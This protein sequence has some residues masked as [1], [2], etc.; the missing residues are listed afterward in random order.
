MDSRAFFYA[1]KKGECNVHELVIASAERLITIHGRNEP[2][3]AQPRR[4]R[5]IDELQ[6]LLKREY[7]ASENDPELRERFLD[8]IDKMLELGL[9]GVDEI[10]KAHE[11]E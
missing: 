4:H 7:A 6:D 1:L 2:G 8:V 11:R 5:G 10:L 9:Y 3:R